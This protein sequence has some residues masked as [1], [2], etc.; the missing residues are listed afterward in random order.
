MSQ[1]AGHHVQRARHHLQRVLDRA[2]VEPEHARGEQDRRARGVLDELVAAETRARRPAAPLASWPCGAPAAA[3]ATGSSSAA[4]TAAPAA[5]AAHP[6]SLVRVALDQPGALVEFARRTRLVVD[7]PGGDHH[8]GVA[9]EARSDPLVDRQR[10][11]GGDRPGRRRRHLEQVGADGVHRDAVALGV[12]GGRLDAARIDVDREDGLP[13]HGR[14]GDRQHAGAAA[15]VGEASRRLELEQQREAHPRRRM[16]ARAERARGRLDHELG[17]P[18]GRR[19]I[20]GRAHA[21]PPGDLPGPT[22][23]TAAL[24]ARVGHLLLVLRQQRGARHRRQL[25]GAGQRPGEAVERDLRAVVIERTLVDALRQ[26]GHQQ[27]EDVLDRIGAQ[28]QRDAPHG[29]STSIVGRG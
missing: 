21:Q 6:R 29:T 13:P 28:G 4:L 20:L 23:A 24:L 3:A 7:Q 16:R 1:R 22:G 25:G 10:D 15:E 2:H 19:G 11:V 14:G 12:A 8:A 27:V 18:V 17:Q 5:S 9:V 26:Q